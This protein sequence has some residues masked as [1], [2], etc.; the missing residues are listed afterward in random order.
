M[1]SRPLM[2]LSPDPSISKPPITPSFAF[3]VPVKVPLF[4]NTSPLNLYFLLTGSSSNTTS[5]STNANI[6]VRFVPSAPVRQSRPIAT[7]V[8]F[9]LLSFVPENILGDTIY[10]P[11]I[12]VL[13]LFHSS[14]LSATF[15]EIQTTDAVEFVCQPSVVPFPVGTAGSVSLS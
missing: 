15:C 12:S 1:A 9:P 11:P 6:P 10:S 3:T 7:P 13:L 2:F 5:S 14:A 4:A 8:S